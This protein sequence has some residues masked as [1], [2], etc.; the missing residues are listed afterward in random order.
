MAGVR[1][2]SIVVEDEDG[3]QAEL[4]TQFVV[5]ES[6]KSC[7]LSLGQLYRAGWSV[8]QNSSG[9][10][11]EFP[12]R[13][14]RVPVFF[15]RNSLAIRGE[16]C[17]VVVAGD[18]GLDVPMVRAVVEL[19]D[20]FRPEMIQFNRWETAVDGNSFLRSIGE[21]YID[22]SVVWPANF[23]YITTLIQNVQL[24]MRT[25]DRALSRSPSGSWTWTNP[26]AGFLRLTLTLVENKLSA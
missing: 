7:I 26:S 13:T 5:S 16:V 2:A 3:S 14:L 24:P 6:V 17:R 21:N 25:T 10:T 15:Q 23:K 20:K 18:S 9:P 22:P 8:Q 19:E 4:E 1:T 11:L 12:D